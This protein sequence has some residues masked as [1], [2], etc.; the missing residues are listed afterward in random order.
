MSDFSSEDRV[1][2]VNQPTFD[3]FYS[4]LI[5]VGLMDFHDCMRVYKSSELLKTF[6]V[7]EKPM[8]S[9]T[10]TCIVSL[11]ITLSI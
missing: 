8:I 4:S 2:T 7:F 9:C 1:N 5:P 11:L 10:V 3:N 6:V